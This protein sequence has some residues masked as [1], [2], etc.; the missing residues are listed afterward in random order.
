MRNQKLET[1]NQTILKPQH[2]Y[3][4]N[5]PVGVRTTSLNA[6]NSIWD[7]LGDK[8]FKVLQ[9]VQEIGGKT[10]NRQLSMKLFW[11]INRVTPRVNELVKLG[12][13]RYGGHTLDKTTNKSVCYWELNN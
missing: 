7:K 1:G 5:E 12:A 10:T 2:I 8:Q 4:D 3:L 13:L 9:A 6:F 11:S